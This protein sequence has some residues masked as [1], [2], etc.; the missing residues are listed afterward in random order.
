VV[1]GAALVVSE[2]MRLV[3]TLVVMAV[4]VFHLRLLALLLVEQA[5][6]AALQIQ[7]ER[8]VQARRV[9]E[10]VEFQG[11][12]LPEPLTQAEAEAAMVVD[13][14]QNLAVQASLFSKSPLSS[15]RH[16]QAVLLPRSRL[17][18]QAL[19]FTP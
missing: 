3:L 4:R 1:V 8:L 19:T 15:Q 9:E 12:L 18:Y 7:A 16:S 14:L 17:R 13:R 2:Q 10:M 6:V 11:T 5:A